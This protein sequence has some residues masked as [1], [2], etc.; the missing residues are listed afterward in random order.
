MSNGIREQIEK[1]TPSYIVAFFSAIEGI[2]TIVLIANPE[3]VPNPAFLITSI[4]S[5]SIVIVLVG[6]LIYRNE[7]YG[8]NIILESRI[9]PAIITTGIYVTLAILRIYGILIISAFLQFLITA[10]IFSLPAF[11][12]DIPYT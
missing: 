8:R 12:K 4:V 7:I 3:E 9:I 10:W 11:I 2:L 1:M 6:A 5:I